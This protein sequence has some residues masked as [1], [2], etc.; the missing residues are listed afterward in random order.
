[1]NGSLTSRRSF[2]KLSAAVGTLATLT[3]FALDAAENDSS[4]PARK[5]NIKKAIMGGTIGLK[6]SLVEKYTA[7]KAAGFE[8]VEPMSHMPQAE[9]LEALEKSGLQAASVCCSTHWNQT[10]SDPDPAIRQ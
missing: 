3:P 5:R 4:A 1:M 6:G 7:L 9:V 10:L 8:G 2:L